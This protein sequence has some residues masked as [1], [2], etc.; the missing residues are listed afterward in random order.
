M[1]RPSRS[2][3]DRTQPGRLRFGHRDGVLCADHW[4]RYADE[5]EDGGQACPEDGPR[6]V[7]ADDPLTGFAAGTPVFRG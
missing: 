5:Y 1:P 7:C 4:D 3:P 2:D 6:E